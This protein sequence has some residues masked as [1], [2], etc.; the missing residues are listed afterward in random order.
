MTNKKVA[1]IAGT[2][3][4]AVKKYL[5]IVSIVASMIG[6]GRE[7]VSWDTQEAA[8]QQAKDNSEFN[9]K[10]LRNAQ[11]PNYTLI[12]RGD[13]TIGPNC[14][15]GDG[16]ATVDMIPADGTAGKKIVLKCSTVSG[17]IGCMTDEDF[18]ARAQYANQDGTC[19]KTLP[20]PLPKIVK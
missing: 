19:N 5:V 1:I 9:A 8:R 10:V 16:W 11:Y 12:L 17:T 4:L 14:K 6:C 18:K 20:F 2:K 13:S 3:G 7:K 15:F